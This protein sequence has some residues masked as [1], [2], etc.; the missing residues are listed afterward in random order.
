MYGIK[1]HLET[2][3]RSLGVVA[4]GDDWCALTGGQSNYVWRVTGAQ[5]VVVKL[6][7]DLGANPIYANT[8]HAEFE[9]L[10]VLRGTDIAPEP[11]GL[12]ETSQGMVL[13][14]EFIQGQIWDDNVDAVAELLNQLHER[15]PVSGVRVI[16]TTGDYIHDQAREILAG[17]SG[18]LAE[19]VKQ[20]EPTPVTVSEVRP[21]LI[22]TD[23][24][25]GNLIVSGQGLRLIDWQCPAMGDPVV[26]IA[27][28]LSPAM[29]AIYGDRQLSLD[30]EEQFLAGFGEELRSRY[31]V[32][33][34]VYHWRMAAYCAWRADQ[35]V[36]GYALAAEA[37]LARLY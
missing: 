23:V 18:R 33:A 7:T 4:E 15:P 30:Q 36:A 22:H 28:F 25:P 32:L 35:G 26:D 37:E 24:V 19:R 8:P 12:H 14:Y 3:L 16:S 17:L 27:M 9:C 6:F 5:D 29:H 11:V 21:C 10:T 20:A 2:D 31:M 34:P 1:H 13:I